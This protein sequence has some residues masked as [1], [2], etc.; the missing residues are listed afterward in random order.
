M[1]KRNGIKT[2]YAIIILAII[3]VAGLAAYIL[4]QGPAGVTAKPKIAVVSD[5][6][7]RGD[8]SFNDM[9]FKGAEEAA[10]DFGWDVMEL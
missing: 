5:I 10:R 7:G 3:V 8:L 9:G 6:G 4:T 2:I 1:K